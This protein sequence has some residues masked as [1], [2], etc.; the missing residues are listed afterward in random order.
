L[1]MTCQ[2]KTRHATPRRPRHGRGIHH[3][4]GWQAARASQPAS[5][6]QPDGKPDAQTRDPH[7][8][9][10]GPHGHGLLEACRLARLVK[11]F[12]SESPPQVHA[13][14][15][16][17]C[18]VSRQRQ[19]LLQVHDLLL[20]L[21]PEVYT[22]LPIPSSQRARISLT[23]DEAHRILT[24]PSVSCLMTEQEAPFWPAQ[25]LALLCFALLTAL[26]SLEPSSPLADLPASMMAASSRVGV[27]V[28]W[29]ACAQRRSS[30]EPCLLRSPARQ[31]LDPT[32]WSAAQHSISGPGCR[33]LASFGGASS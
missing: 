31:V 13:D 9:L 7:I 23:A 11:I 28:A 24:R 29:L 19:P 27:R 2:G 8:S 25:G 15:R 12:C 4:A 20:A 1:G 6:R 22:Y 30:P 32:R 5:E 18:L 17:A 26:I 33:L 16:K 21:L 10:G 3:K 14:Q